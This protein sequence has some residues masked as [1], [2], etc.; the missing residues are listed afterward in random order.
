VNND[1][2]LGI[3]DLAV[4]YNG[5]E[6]RDKTCNSINSL[7]YQVSTLCPKNP[8]FYGYSPQ[9]MRN[10]CN[11]LSKIGVF[12]KSIKK[13]GEIIYVKKPIIRRTKWRREPDKY[14]WC[15]SPGKYHMIVTTNKYKINELF[16][17]QV[18][19]VLAGKIP[20]NSLIESAN[21]WKNRLFAFLKNNKFDDEIKEILLKMRKW[22]YG[23]KYNEDYWARRLKLNRRKR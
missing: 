3:L 20:L 14:N 17:R 4:F 12:T 10:Y 9:T 16:L 18:K 6:V 23:L 22:W 7:G 19:L 21:S 11:T 1:V 2:I 13:T 15:K 5:V 8:I